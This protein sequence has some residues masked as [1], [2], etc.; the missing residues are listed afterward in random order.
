M[1]PARTRTIP[2]PA[3][4][5]AASAS[6]PLRRPRDKDQVRSR[7]RRAW[8][9]E[10]SRHQQHR[11]SLRTGRA[12]TRSGHEPVRM[13]SAERAEPTSDRVTPLKRYLESYRRRALRSP[14]PAGRSAPVRGQRCRD[15]GRRRS[16]RREPSTC[17][18]SCPRIP[19]RSC[20]R[21]SN[22]CARW[23]VEAVSRST[24]EPSGWSPSFSPAGA[25][26]RVLRA[27]EASRVHQHQA[28]ELR[29]GK[30]ALTWLH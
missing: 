29:A 24:G 25:T 15:G 20:H 13:P 5:S 11:G 23:D 12:R 14:T 17:V 26:R 9:E 6:C 1:R 18:G 4:H 21:P 2:T 19:P 3:S 7:R 22:R 16:S 10:A 28:P 27:V 30:Q 8:R